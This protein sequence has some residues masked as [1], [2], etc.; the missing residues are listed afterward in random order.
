MGESATADGRFFNRDVNCIRRF[1]R[2][3]FRFEGTTWPVWADVVSEWDEYEKRKQA[4]AKDGEGE[5]GAAAEGEEGEEQD[6][7]GTE[8]P[9]A[10]AIDS[11][12]AETEEAGDNDDFTDDPPFLRLDL[13]VEATGFNRDMQRQLE[14][15]SSFDKSIGS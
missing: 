13:E 6:E 4:T 3:R 12:T 15:V 11:E 10:A 14:D 1:F 9:V 2:K 5:E 7:A 8:P